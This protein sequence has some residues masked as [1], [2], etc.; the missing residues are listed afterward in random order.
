MKNTLYIPCQH[1]NVCF[2]MPIIHDLSNTHAYNP[3]TKASHLT[4]NHGMSACVN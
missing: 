1:I 3:P 4:Q 2:D